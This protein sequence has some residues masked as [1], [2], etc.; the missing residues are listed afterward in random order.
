MVKLCA[1]PRGYGATN[2]GGGCTSGS[3]A[4]DSQRLGLQGQDSE[5]LREMG[6]VRSTLYFP[7]RPHD[8]ERECAVAEGWDRNHGGQIGGTDQCGEASN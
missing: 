5:V 2:Q 1:C 4:P 7:R 3:R 8:Q 6:R